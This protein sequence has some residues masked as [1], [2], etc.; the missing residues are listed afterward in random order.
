M[1]IERSLKQFEE[2]RKNSARIAARLLLASCVTSPRVGGVGE[3]SVHILDEDTDIE[4]LCQQ[5]ELMAEENTAWEFFKKDAAML[6]DADAVLVVTSLRSLTDPS[7]INCNMCGKLTCEYLREEPKLPQEPGVA[8]TGPLCSFR[9]NNIAY[10]IDGIVA[11]ARNLGIDYGVYWS[12]GA[13][14][15]RMGILPRATGFALGVGIS[16]TEKSPFRDIPEKYD[17]INERTM[18]DRIIS[19]LWPQ[20]RSIYS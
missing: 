16:V 8:F 19:R 3:C 9:A 17:E 13:A 11:L 18:N 1:S 5:I 10:A 14:A 15:M 12:V 20:F 2:E 6:R 7:D 4:D